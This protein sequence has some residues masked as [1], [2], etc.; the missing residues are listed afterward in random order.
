MP[1]RRMLSVMRVLAVAL[2][3]VVE[4]PMKRKSPTV[5]MIG[6]L[7][8]AAVSDRAD[9]AEIHVEILELEAPALG[10]AILAAAADDEAG[11]GRLAAEGAEDTRGAGHA[12]R[13]VGA[14]LA[15]REAAGHV[16]QQVGIGEQA[17]AS[18]QRAEPAQM[19]VGGD[20]GR[21][22]RT[23]RR[24]AERAAAALAGALEVRLDAEHPVVELGVVADL[25]A[26]EPAVHP[27]AVAEAAVVV[28]PGTVVTASTVPPSVVL[29]IVP[30]D[31]CVA[32]RSVL[33]RP[34][35]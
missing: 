16:E 7:V 26:E 20:H 32:A 17:G 19:E 14:D 5:T 1:A 8:W 25:S 3:V 6:R 33:A 31:V 30:M 11:A 29:V 15:D 21:A 34:Q 18:A 24:E 23:G 10:E 22:E 13:I 4:T 27:G 12:R 28:G 9:R 35:L 2:V